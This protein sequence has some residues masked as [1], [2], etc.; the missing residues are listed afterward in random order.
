MRPLFT[1]IRRLTY[2]FSY[3]ALTTAIGELFES[4]N[5]PVGVQ[6]FFTFLSLALPLLCNLMDIRVG[7]IAS[8][9]LCPFTTDP[10]LVS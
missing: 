10:I 5:T 4:L 6:G 7:S 8:S 1:Q 9:Q 3:A 2:C